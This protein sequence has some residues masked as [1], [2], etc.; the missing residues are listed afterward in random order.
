MTAIT[1]N[2]ISCRKE[3]YSQAKAYFDNGD[4]AFPVEQMEFIYGICEPCRFP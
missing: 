3:E 4:T 2:C 1:D